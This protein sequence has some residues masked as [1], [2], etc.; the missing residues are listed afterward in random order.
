MAIVNYAIEVRTNKALSANDA[1]GFDG[2]TFRWVTGRPSY[3]GSTVV[4]T[5]E[6]GTPNTHKWA[7]G[8]IMGDGL[9]S[10]SRSI[11]I[12]ETGDYGTLSGFDFSL[13]NDAPADG[14]SPLWMWMRDNHIYFTNREVYF[15]VVIDNKF[16]SVWAGVVANNPYDEINYKFKCQDAFR[17]VHKMIP[18]LVIDRNIYPGSDDE[19]Q[20][21]SV[22][23]CIGDVTYAKLQTVNTEQVP[24]T[25]VLSK[26]LPGE[27]LECGAAGAISY[28]TTLYLTYSD[29][30]WTQD[31]G[32]DY[33]TSASGAFVTDGWLRGGKIEVTGSSG[34]SNNATWTIKS[35]TATQIT[36]NAVGQVTVCSDA[37]V[38]VTF[39]M[40]DKGTPNL[41]LYTKGV[42]FSPN[43]LANKYL[44]VA[45][46]G[47]LADTDRLIRIVSNVETDVHEFTT[48]T[49][50]S[51]FEFVN[52]EQFNKGYAYDPY[53]DY[54]RV[55]YTIM[56]IKDYHDMRT[57]VGELAFYSINSGS[58]VRYE[59]I[60]L[61]NNGVGSNMLSFRFSQQQTNGWF[62][63][64]LDS[65]TGPVI[66]TSRL[67]YKWDIGGRSQWQD[68]PITRQ[69]SNDATICIVFHDIIPPSG[70]AYT[71]KYYEFKSSVMRS[72]ENTWW[73]SIIAMASSHLISDR[74]LKEYVT[75]A[76][77]IPLLFIYNK[78][79][80]QMERVDSQA[81]SVTVD[82]SGSTG[83]PELILYSS[84]LNKDGEVE[85]LVR[86]PPVQWGVKVETDLAIR[87]W[88]QPYSV[89]QDGSILLRNPT[90]STL[91]DILLPVSQVNHAMTKIYPSINIGDRDQSTYMEMRFPAYAGAYTNMYSFTVQMVI[92]EEFLDYDLSKIYCCLD[93]KATSSRVTMPGPGGPLIRAVVAFDV[94]DPY[95]NIINYDATQDYE[96]A[97]IAY[98]LDQIP[99]T[100]V[101]NMFCLPKMYYENGGSMLYPE[102]SLWGL[103][104]KDKDDED[105]T[106]QTM[107]E[108]PSEIFDAIKDGTSSRIVQMRVLITSS[109]ATAEGGEAFGLNVN[110]YQAGFVG[111]RSTNP[112]NDDYYCRIKGETLP[113]GSE[114][115]TVYRAF[116]LMMESYDGIPGSMIDY[117]N[118]PVVRDDWTVGRQLTDRKN[119]FDY[120]RE[121]AKHSFVGVYPTRDGKRGLKAWREDVETKRYITQDDIVRDSIKNWTR[122][123]VADLYNDFRL[124]YNWNEASGNYLDSITVSKTDQYYPVVGGVTGATAGF[125]SATGMMDYPNN[126]ELWKVYVGGI[127]PDSYT[128]AEIMWRFAHEGYDLAAATQELPKSLSEL[129]WYINTDLFGSKDF[130]GA[131]KLDSPYKYME[132]L[133]LWCT[134]LKDEVKFDLPITGSN[135]EL[136]LL[137]FVQLNDIIYTGGETRVGWITGIEIV[138]DK[139][140]MR[141]TVLLNPDMIRED[142]VI[143]ERGQLLNFNKYTESGSYTGIILDGQGR[144]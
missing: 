4:P 83:H 1:Y 43:Q 121:L 64:R 46:G 22:P 118:L 75:D 37:G 105:T 86:V 76:A 132:N 89:V 66:G 79:K 12:A 80:K 51:P 123:S 109:G 70:P 35:V 17:K 88:G 116:K 60:D 5:W 67:E 122:T 85:Y 25:V 30:V 95:G 68:V 53:Y 134:L 111:L 11:D 52:E 24:E 45:K 127:S 74:S 27:N 57:V 124:W 136:E 119:S 78:D 65:S 59:H 84:N 138:P 36:L 112:L 71:F 133:V 90:V 31:I 108:L 34:L 7:E 130:Q 107:M 139:M 81:L 143:R 28:D 49:L 14:A 55:T 102:L 93:M 26:N 117:T 129:P 62:E 47:G 106:L 61:S 120:I 144:I 23:I 115:N 100:S 97:A 98:P 99:A 6:D 103:A 21:K 41:T 44:Y 110:L 2:S 33:I 69:Y 15:Y 50:E 38:S 32:G 9:E 82:Q 92:P 42:H 104:G 39:G 29:L 114:T 128:D 141:I 40:P 13:R 126:K 135:V 16:Y 96:D 77:N 8:W 54:D 113:D 94:L 20:G 91:P 3:D 72:N 142:L 58:W 131:T 18:P 73:F 125:P 48:I 63:V 56:S 87:A 140:V 10:P 19:A 137:D 101:L